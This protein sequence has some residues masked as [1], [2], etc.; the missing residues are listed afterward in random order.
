[1]AK[2]SATIYDVAGMAGVSIATVSRV[3]NGSAP[4]RQET[5]ERVDSA[6]REL[7]F[8]PNSAA[9]S[10]SG[11]RRG[12]IGLVYPLDEERTGQ[13]Q[14]HEDDATV[15]YT[16][17]I[18]RGAT[19]QAARHGC[20]LLT[21]AVRIGRNTGPR[22]L[23]QVC[24][25]VGGLIVTDR[26]AHHVGAMR[27]AT[28]MRAVHLS[29]SGSPKFG[30]AISVDNGSGIA[31]LMAH[32]AETHGVQDFGYVDGIVDSPDAVARAEAFRSCL[33]A[34][35]GVARPENLLVG[36]FSMARAAEALAA[37]LD[38]PAPLPQVFVCANDQM[39][40]GV[41]R[42]LERRGISVPGEVLVTGFDDVAL[43]RQLQPGLTT[44]AQ[45]SFALGV[46]AVDLVIGLLDGEIPAGTVQTLPTELVVRSSCGCPAQTDLDAMNWGYLH[47][48]S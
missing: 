33:G 4:V 14:L 37:R 48:A 10:L 47:A 2:R 7:H 39:A 5:R 21:C 25:A 16:D 15:L 13:G 45:P 34:L 1:M 38:H 12:S 6:V 19:W 46:A 29:G 11:G 27:T 35:G 24:S 20:V 36:E 41:V 32:L 26:V 9:R 8:V 42:T 23:Q 18:I 28:R 40:L 3:L 43:A 31:A 44:V 17:A 22:A 30:G